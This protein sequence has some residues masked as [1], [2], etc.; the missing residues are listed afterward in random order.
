[1]KASIRFP[2]AAGVAA[3]D[4]VDRFVRPRDRFKMNGRTCP[5]GPDRR[6]GISKTDRREQ[7]ENEQ[8]EGMA[9]RG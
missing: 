9:N 8:Q 6:K 4:W 3:T 1:L 7:K 2:V 5:I